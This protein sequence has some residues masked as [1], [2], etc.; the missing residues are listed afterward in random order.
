MINAE[1][2]TY[3][4]YL[5]QERNEYGQETLTEQPQGAITMAIFLLNQSV[6]D[7]I[8]YKDASYI[9]LTMA[10]IDD[11]FVIEYGEKKLKVLTV[12]LQGRYKQCFLS[13]I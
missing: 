9:G 10:A 1:M 5:F 6:T 13:E 7:N 3:N 11:S 4:Y 8:K 2:R 12:T